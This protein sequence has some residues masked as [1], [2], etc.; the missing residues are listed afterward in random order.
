MAKLPERQPT[1]PPSGNS[2]QKD[3]GFARFLKKHSSP[4]HQRVTTGGRIV[5]MEQRPPIFSLQHP[6]QD[7]EEQKKSTH[8]E[9]KGT[10]KTTAASHD[11]AKSCVADNNILPAQPQQL[12][13]VS[14]GVIDASA[15]TTGT[16]PSVIAS[17]IP[18]SFDATC[19]QPNYLQAMSPAPFYAGMAGDPY[20]MLP[21]HSQMYPGS[22][23]PFAGF[24]GTVGPTFPMPF[25]PNPHML[26]F[27]PSCGITTTPTVPEIPTGSYAERMVNQFIETFENLGEQLKNLDRHRAMNERDPYVVD[28]RK[29]I[30]QLRA[31]ARDQITFW[32]GKLGH[33]PH[34]IP[35]NPS[36]APN[37]KLN[38][39]AT[40][41]VPFRG[42][43]TAE[44]L[45]DSRGSSLKTNGISQEPVKPDFIVD[46]TRRPIPI[47]PPPGRFST[48]QK[49]VKDDVASKSESVEVDEWGIRVGPAPPE[50]QR[51]QNQ[52]LKEIVRQASISPLGSS[53]N[54]VMFT[55]QGSQVITPPTQPYETKE[56]KTDTDSNA[57][58]W[59]PTNPG[60]AP[61]TVEACYEVQLNAMRLPKG[62]VTKVRMPDGTIT[63]VRGCG[64][65]RPPSFEM[66]EFEQRYWTTKP[67][68]TKEMFENFVEVRADDGNNTP[69][70]VANY[71]EFIGLERYVPM[72][73]C[74]VQTLVLTVASH[75]TQMRKSEVSNR[76]SNESM[77]VAKTTTK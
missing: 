13:P 36:G 11:Q 39:Q 57:S 12:I 20:S 71:L 23:M 69:A 6:N 70:N 59:L 49:D 31:E 26:G 48:L 50:I 51:Q 64:L 18:F 28:Q 67:N 52:M 14:N 44:T 5:P 63:E 76:Q 72:A 55:P 38:V 73:S 16:D 40:S 29:A 22:A 75:G 56:A 3:E 9:V 60:R 21:L 1:V 4:T 68:V 58:D 32:S 66:D 46:S 43:Q 30:V 19:M 17:S 7:T 41:Y 47:V 74:S 42:E 65:K 37:S 77:H 53:E 27:P 15:F 24:N 35:K 10:T 45:S 33:D 54:A 62:L 61:P 8:G 34:A 25:I 2:A